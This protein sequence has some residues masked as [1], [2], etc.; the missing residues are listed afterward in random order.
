MGPCWARSAR[1]RPVRR[2]PCQ[3][4]EARLISARRSGV[5]E[6]VVVGVIARLVQRCAARIRSV[7]V[8]GLGLPHPSGIKSTFG[9][10]HLHQHLN[11]VLKYKYTSTPAAVINGT[12]V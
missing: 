8:A 10:S 4:G 7:L 1:C 5:P 12:N 3:P 2:R 6:G 9:P 11:K